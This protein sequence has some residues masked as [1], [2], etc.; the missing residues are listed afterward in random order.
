MIPTEREYP[1]RTK[2]AT[3]ISPALFFG[4][5][6]VVLFVQAAENNQGI[7]IREVVK[8]SPESASTLLW[9]L[10]CFSLVFVLLAFLLAAQRLTLRQR[11]VL[12]DNTLILPKSRWSA[13]GVAI[14][15]SE[16][17]SLSASRAF[18]Y[19]FLLIDYGKGR[20]ALN[21][22]ML[23]KKGD[24]DDIHQFVDERM[25]YVRSGVFY[26]K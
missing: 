19:R 15:Y 24:I 2:W 10:G 4:L 9:V 14:P 23:P 25:R 18:N 17:V 21:A 20:F 13:K 5:S 3:I 8:L 22:S 16:I 6:A 11:V 12:T 1:Y 26:Q 7:T